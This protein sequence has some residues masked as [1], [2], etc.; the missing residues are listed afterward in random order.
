MQKI[1]K[2]RQTVAKFRF[3]ALFAG[4]K[5]NHVAS[6]SGLQALSSDRGRL[7]TEREFS[8]LRGRL[9]TRLEIKRLVWF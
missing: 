7:G 5:R 1:E 6:S 3:R 4:V 8:R 9:G 2:Y